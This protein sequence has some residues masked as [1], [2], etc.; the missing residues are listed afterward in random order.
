[1]QF[2]Y[3]LNPAQWEALRYL[4]KANRY[5]AS[6][7]AMADYLGATKGTVSQTLIALES[8]GL[9]RRDRCPNDRRAIVLAL[10]AAGHEMLVQDPLC[11]IYAVTEKVPEAERQQL[12]GVMKSILDDLCVKHNNSQFGVCGDCCHLGEGSCAGSGTCGVTGD[13]LEATDI[14]L[15]CIDFSP[16]NGDKLPPLK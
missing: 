1:M 16:F 7:S 11:Q 12:A 14:K 8:K 2:S 5:S 4:N 6:P 13:A 15:I 3:G 9:I 10:T